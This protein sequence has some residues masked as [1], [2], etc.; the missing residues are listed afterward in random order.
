M[1]ETWLRMHSLRQDSGY[2]LMSGGQVT[3]WIVGLFVKMK[4]TRWGSRG[5][6]RIRVRLRCVSDEQ[7][8]VGTVM[9]SKTLEGRPLELGTHGSC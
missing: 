9:G 8:G 3:W 7:G 2:L 4:R 5:T 1:W 6:G